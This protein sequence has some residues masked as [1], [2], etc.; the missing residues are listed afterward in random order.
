MAQSVTYVGPYPEVVV[1]LDDDNFAVMSPGG[2]YDVPDDV[3]AN[4][5]EQGAVVHASAAGDGAPPHSA[6]KDEW[7]AYRTAQGHV[8]DG[9]TKT[10]LIELPDAPAEED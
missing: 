8:V 7:S 4:L 5:L 3:A 2:V 1:W 10:E 9:L 6:T